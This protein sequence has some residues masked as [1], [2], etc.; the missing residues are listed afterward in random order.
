LARFAHDPTALI[1]DVPR[2]EIIASLSLSAL[3]ACELIALRRG[4]LEELRRQTLGALS[5]SARLASGALDALPPVS[6]VLFPESGFGLRIATL[7]APLHRRARNL[8]L[9]SGSGVVGAVLCTQQTTAAA[10]A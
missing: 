8:A 5:R 7:R 2:P 1:V 10:G 9:Q 4:V 3:F 6:P